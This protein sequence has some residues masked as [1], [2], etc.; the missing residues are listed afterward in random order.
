[1]TIFIIIVI[2]VGFIIWKISSQT[3]PQDPFMTSIFQD[4][5]Y[6]DCNVYRS[7]I[8]RK[9]YVSPYMLQTGDEN[10]FSGTKFECE[11]WIEQNTF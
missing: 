8:T 5:D 3:K 6:P 7:K 11:R 10:K 4:T 1:M 2:I 9:Y